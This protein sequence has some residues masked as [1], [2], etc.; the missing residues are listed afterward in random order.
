MA[1]NYDLENLR[2]DDLGDSEVLCHYL[3][4]LYQQPVQQFKLVPL[5]TPYLECEIVDLA[6][7]QF[8]G[9]WSDGTFDFSGAND[10]VIA[11]LDSLFRRYLP[12]RHSN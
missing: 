3:K 6:S 1:A 2:V 9:L 8:L 12:V 10:A 5:E 7:Q 4:F 11:N